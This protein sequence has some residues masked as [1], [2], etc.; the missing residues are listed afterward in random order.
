LCSERDDRECLD[1]LIDELCLTPVLTPELISRIVADVCTRVPGMARTGGV[2]RLQRLIRAEAWVDAVLSL[3]EL[4]L[5]MWR[6]RRLIHDGGEWV[7]S[8]SRHPEMPIELDAT[9]DGRHHAPAVAMLLALIEAKRLLMGCEPV[10]ATSVPQVAPEP[11]AY[12][13][14]CDNFG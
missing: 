8:L 10:G 3:V 9:A 4:E 5:P 6:P 14:C 11:A 2:A 7:C 13:L 1:R 12:V